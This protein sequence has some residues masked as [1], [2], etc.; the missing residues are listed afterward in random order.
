MALTYQIDHANQVMVSRWVGAI[1]D[2]AVVTF[3]TEVLA[4]PAFDFDI[5]EI[6]DLREADLGELTPDG[7]KRLYNVLVEGIQA[8]QQQGRDPDKVARAA[9]IAPKDRNFG[10]GRMY[11]AHAHP[12]VDHRPFREPVEALAWLDLPSDYLED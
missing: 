6:V 7:L 4:D 2:D 1:T 8:E 3:Y 11:S 9:V 10:L 12:L 5:R